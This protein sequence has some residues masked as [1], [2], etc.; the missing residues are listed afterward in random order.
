MAISTWSARL[1]LTPAFPSRATP[2]PP[3]PAGN[4]TR[5]PS[6][7]VSGHRR[8][9]QFARP[10]PPRAYIS[11]PAPGPEAAYA[12][13]SLDAAAAAADVAAAISSSDA[14]TW[15]GVWALL[16]RHRA[17]IAV[18]VAALLACTTCT[19]SMP[20][21]SGRFF[22]TLIGRGSEPLWRLLS[23]IAVLYALEPIFTIIFVINMTVIW[24]QVMARLR[25]QIF[26]RILI[27]KMVFFDRHKVGELT[28]LL[29]S[30]L[31]SLKNLVSDNIS[32]DRGLRALSEITGTL[33]I[34]FTLSTELAPVLGLLMVSVSVLVGNLLETY[35]QHV[36]LTARRC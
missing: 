36:P 35:C 3:L 2:P 31:G 34:L 22:E 25:S 12:P 20:L 33:C 30:D 19:L 14:V 13:P 24:E 1:L 28:G 5:V 6:V 18:S 27:Q 11:A 29:T 32:R 8:S 16:S 23:K 26:R 9:L 21:F 7:S 17:R 15:A 4:R 10:H